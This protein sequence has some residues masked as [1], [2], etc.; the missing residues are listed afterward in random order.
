MQNSHLRR[1]SAHPKYYFPISSLLPPQFPDTPLLHCS[2]TVICL[3]KFEA[4]AYSVTPELLNSSNFSLSGTDTC[5][6]AY[7]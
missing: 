4:R 5:T 3:L 2:K 7:R 1:E 6:S